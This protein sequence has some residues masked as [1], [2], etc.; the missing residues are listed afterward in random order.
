MTHLDNKDFFDFATAA[1]VYGVTSDWDFGITAKGSAGDLDNDAFYGV[2][3]LFHKLGNIGMKEK[4]IYALI[5]SQLDRRWRNTDWC[6]IDNLDGDEFDEV[7]I[8][9]RGIQSFGLR[10]SILKND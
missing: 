2:R 6:N 7:D 3:E 5:L 9:G 8:D 1:E 10:R 4:E